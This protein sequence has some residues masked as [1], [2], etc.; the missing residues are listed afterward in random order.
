LTVHPGGDEWKAERAARD[1]DDVVQLYIHQRCGT[2]SRPVREL[3]AFERVSIGA[4]TTRTVEFALGPDQLRY[5]S[6]VTGGYVQD[7]TTLDLWVGGSS[8]ADLTTELIVT[9]LRPLC[10]KPF[11]AAEGDEDIAR[12]QA[13]PRSLLELEPPATILSLSDSSFLNTGRIALDDAQALLDLANRV[14]PH[15]ARG[16]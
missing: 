1:A 14:E 13:G 7:A 11:G 6:A 5:W 15:A 16:P 4:G 3:K 9:R 10:G 12:G 2:S 8:A